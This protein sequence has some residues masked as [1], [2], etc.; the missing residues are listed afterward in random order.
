ML[1]QKCSY[2]F[3]KVIEKTLTIAEPNVAN[4]E[5]KEIVFDKSAVLD[6]H[7]LNMKK[8]IVIHKIKQII[9]VG[10]EPQ[11]GKLVFFFY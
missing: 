7:N 2:T 11:F 8:V 9:F 5:P 10:E 3:D 6:I 1:Q 4:I